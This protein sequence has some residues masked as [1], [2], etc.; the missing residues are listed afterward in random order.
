MEV[1]EGNVL[2]DSGAATTLIHKNFA[3]ALGLQDKREPL[4]AEF[5]SQHE[6][7]DCTTVRRGG[8]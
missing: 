6:V 3:K 1:R 2:I 5:Q 4:E 7:S 8:I